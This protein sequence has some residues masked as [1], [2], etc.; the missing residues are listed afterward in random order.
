MTFHGFGIYGSYYDSNL[1]YIVKWIIND[2]ESE[3]YTFCPDDTKKDEQ[4]KWM[5]IHLKQQF[6]QEPIDLKAGD[7]LH[8]VMMLKSSDTYTWHTTVEEDSWR[9]I[10]DQNVDFEISNSEHNQLSTS[11]TTGQFP[12]IIYAK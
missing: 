12:F 4:T 11:T 9:T 5:E 10:E 1:E 8:I 3:K 2:V 6:E 7:S